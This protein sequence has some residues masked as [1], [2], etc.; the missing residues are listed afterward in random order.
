MFHSTRGV[1]R[2]RDGAKHLTSLLGVRN[3][4]P[5][6][7]MGGKKYS[8][9]HFGGLKHNQ[10]LVFSLIEERKYFRM[11]IFWGNLE[12]ME[13]FVI[14]YLFKDLVG[15]S[16]QLKPI[17]NIFLKYRRRKKSCHHSPHPRI[18]TYDVTKYL[19]FDHFWPILFKKLTQLMRFY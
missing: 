4:S 7:P 17:T 3:M 5:T 1:E 19:T 12:K 8:E 6:P 16:H 18:L 11:S 15:Q 2:N 13:Y 9:I 10:H 14:F